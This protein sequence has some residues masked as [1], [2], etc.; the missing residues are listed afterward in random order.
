MRLLDFLKLW[1][2]RFVEE[3]IIERI[4]KDSEERARRVQLMRILAQTRMAKIPDEVHDITIDDT[5]DDLNKHWYKSVGSDAKAFLE[6]LWT[7]APEW[8]TS[9]SIMVIDGGTKASRKRFLNLVLCMAIK[10][11]QKEMDDVVKRL[12]AFEILPILNSFS[13]E[14]LKLRNSLVEAPVLALTGFHPGTVPRINTD[15][16]LLLDSLF[17]GRMENR[18]LTILTLDK[19]S[20]EF[21][22]CK[23]LF[24]ATFEEAVASGPDIENQIMRIKLEH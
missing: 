22:V 21:E 23:G 6:Y 4:R 17:I 2:D 18:P 13:D 8:A 3:E 14:R 20:D 15:G 12:H 7:C 9:G 1:G 24:G 5:R 19:P 16:A 11:N 10:A